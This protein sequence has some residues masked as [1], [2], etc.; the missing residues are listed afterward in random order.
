MK[1]RVTIHYNGQI[2]SDTFKKAGRK[3]VYR[4]VKIFERLRYKNALEY[5]DSLSNRYYNR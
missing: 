5:V 2:Y 1:Y 4:N 3:E